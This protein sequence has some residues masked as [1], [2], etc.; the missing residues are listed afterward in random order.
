[1][2]KEEKNNKKSKVLSIISLVLAIISFIL[3]IL[4]VYLIFDVTFE[5]FIFSKLDALSSSMLM[6]V[7]GSTI[8]L[9]AMIFGMISIKIKDNTLARV[10]TMISF[11]AF[12][13]YFLIIFLLAHRR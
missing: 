7:G 2:D 6:F 9:F 3:T 8:V 13:V 11:F 5:I 4:Y 1:M 10:S 12:V